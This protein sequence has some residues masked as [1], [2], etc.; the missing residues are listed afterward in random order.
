MKD[1]SVL[2]D[3]NAEVEIFVEYHNQQRGYESLRNLILADLYCGLGRTILLQREGIKRL[4][5]QQRRLIHQ[6][7]AP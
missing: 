3:L 7:I 4:T 5:M 2:G 1:H 6:Q